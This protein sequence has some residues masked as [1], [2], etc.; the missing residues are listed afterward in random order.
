MIKITFLYKGKR[1]TAAH[2]E[3]LKESIK[4]FMENYLEDDYSY[5]IISTIMRG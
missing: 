1:L 4:A 5:K 2:E 3:T